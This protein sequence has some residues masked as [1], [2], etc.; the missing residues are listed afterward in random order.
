MI[1]LTVK[2]AA[3]KRGIKNPYQLAQRMDKVSGTPPDPDS[4][5]LARRLWKGK[6]QPKMDSLDR[7]SEALGDCDLSE[8]LIRVPNKHT[9]TARRK[10]GRR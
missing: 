10:S 6:V 7:V 5:E 2:E 8:L 4:E 3:L 9:K 1:R